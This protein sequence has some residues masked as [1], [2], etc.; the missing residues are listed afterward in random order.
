MKSEEYITERWIPLVRAA[1]L[2]GSTPLNVLMHVKR[3]LLS[4]VEREAGWLIDPNSLALLLG[5][6]KVGEVLAVCRSGC[7]KIHGC[8]RCGQ[9]PEPVS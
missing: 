2:L 8:E 6:R 5:R 1:E 4:G 3:G 9:A 7:T